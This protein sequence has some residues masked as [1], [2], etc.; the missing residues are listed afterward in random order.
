MEL[1]LTGME[2]REQLCESKRTRCHDKS[3]KSATGVARGEGPHQHWTTK[4]KK[5]RQQSWKS[6]SWVSKEKNQIPQPIVKGGVNGDQRSMPRTRETF[7]A[8]KG[9]KK[10]EN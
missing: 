5:E 1:G 7:Q 10:G 9:L 4:V 3:F 2:A 8:L 6:S